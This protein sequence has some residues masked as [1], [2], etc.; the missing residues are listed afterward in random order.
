MEHNTQ[1]KLTLQQLI[2]RHSTLDSQ[3]VPVKLVLQACFL[4]HSLSSE[5]KTKTHTHL[6]RLS[7]DS[8]V[9]FTYILDPAS[10]YVWY[11]K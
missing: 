1:N 8:K 9:S 6:S 11:F 4:S 7:M 10:L 2:L 5:I 3:V